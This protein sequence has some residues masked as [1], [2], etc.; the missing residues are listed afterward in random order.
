MRVRFCNKSFHLIFYIPASL[1]FQFSIMMSLPRRASQQNT[2]FVH[3]DINIRLKTFPLERTNNMLKQMYS[4]A[5]WQI[6]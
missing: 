2:E 3:F 5:D 1:L 6:S 4:R